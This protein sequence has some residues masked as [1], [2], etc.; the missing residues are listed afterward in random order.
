MKIN[1]QKFFAILSSQNCSALEGRAKCPTIVACTEYPCFVI[2]TASYHTTDKLDHM[3]ALF[4]VLLDVDLT[5]QVF[6]H[7]GIIFIKVRL[8]NLDGNFCVVGLSKNTNTNIENRHVNYCRSRNFCQ[9]NTFRYTNSQ[10]SHFVS[11][12]NIDDPRICQRCHCEHLL[13]VN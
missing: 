1:F 9:R 2:F 11:I 12:S 10:V 3:P 4:Q 13:L 8:D 5:V 7:L 6:P